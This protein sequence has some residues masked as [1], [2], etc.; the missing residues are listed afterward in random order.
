M[1]DV[2]ELNKFLNIEERNEISEN[3]LRLEHDIK[4]GVGVTPGNDDSPRIECEFDEEEYNDINKIC[5][6]AKQEHG[7]FCSYSS[8]YS[9]EC[10]SPDVAL[11]ATIYKTCKI[12]SDH[13]YFENLETSFGIYKDHGG[14]LLYTKLVK[15]LKEQIISTVGEIGLCS[16]VAHKIGEYLDFNDYF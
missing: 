1:A 5:S 3:L 15:F 8:I 2:V 12:T 6:W 10:V 13:G 9:K 14:R 16:D 4:Y 11:L 7:Y